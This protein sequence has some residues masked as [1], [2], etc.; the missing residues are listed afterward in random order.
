MAVRW[1]GGSTAALLTLDRIACIVPLYVPRSTHK[2]YLLEVQTRQL[3]DP[4]ESQARHPKNRAQEVLQTLPCAD[5]AQ[6]SKEIS[7]LSG[8]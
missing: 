2:T 3:L 6:G 8:F 1:A 7:F 4:Q 5:G